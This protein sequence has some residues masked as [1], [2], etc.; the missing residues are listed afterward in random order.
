MDCRRFG[1]PSHPQAGVIEAKERAK[2]IRM[3]DALLAAGLITFAIGHLWLVGLSFRQSTGTGCL[4]F[5]VPLM[6]LNYGA[7]EWPSTKLPV[8]LYLVG[9]GL[10]SVIG[11]LE[12]F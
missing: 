6:S 12:A 1:K 8:I 11:L 4:S 5:L 7:K 10:C 9:I 3:Q 2:L